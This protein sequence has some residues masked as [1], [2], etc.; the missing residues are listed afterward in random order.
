MIRPIGFKAFLKV[1]K[2]IVRVEE[3]SYQNSTISYIYDNYVENEQEWL[4][5]GFEDIVL[6]QYTGLKDNRHQE[7]FEGDIVE[8]INYYQKPATVDVGKIVYQDEF[9]RFAMQSNKWPLPF[10]ICSSEEGFSNIKLKIVGNIFE[11]PELL[12]EN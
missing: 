6:L 3:I 7:I 1:S 8:S 9:A 4:T 12:E 2:E 10:Q 11:N 5:E